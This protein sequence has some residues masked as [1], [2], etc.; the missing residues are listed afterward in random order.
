MVVDIL[1]DLLAESI[2]WKPCFD[3]DPSFASGMTRPVRKWSI[4]N[5]K[6][7]ESKALGLGA[8]HEGPDVRYPFHCGGQPLM[9]CVIDRLTM[10]RYENN[11]G[12]RNDW[13]PMANNVDGPVYVWLYRNNVQID[14]MGVKDVWSQLFCTFIPFANGIILAV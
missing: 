12:V 10:S 9:P 13:K 4:S 11:W 14:H 8:S 6:W 5:Y 3:E 7:T 1:K 2:A